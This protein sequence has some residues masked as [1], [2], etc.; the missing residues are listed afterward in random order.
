MCLQRLPLCHHVF[1]DFGQI[2]D[3]WDTTTEH[4]KAKAKEQTEA[5]RLES[6]SQADFVLGAVTS[7]Q[8]ALDQMRAEGFVDETLNN[9]L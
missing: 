6:V 8:A 4:V 5:I 9:Y 2:I 7:M 1:A 3:A